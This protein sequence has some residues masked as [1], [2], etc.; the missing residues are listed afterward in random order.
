MVITTD[1]ITRM[2]NGLSATE[3]T[4]ITNQ[5]TYLAG[6]VGSGTTTYY[7]QIE[8]LTFSRGSDKMGTVTVITVTGIKISISYNLN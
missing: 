5:L 6:M 1:D 2:Y 7:E 8:T 3:R 4:A